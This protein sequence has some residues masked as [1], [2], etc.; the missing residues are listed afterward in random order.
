MFDLNDLLLAVGF[1]IPVF[2]VW[3]FALAGGRE[4]L[5]YLR[6]LPAS[7][8]VGLLA[9]LGIAVL[10]GGDKPPPPV[11]AVIQQILTVEA[12]GTLKDLSGEV[13][14]GVAAAALDAYVGASAAIVQ[15]ASNVVESARGDLAALT[16]AMAQANYQAAYI[17]Y[18]APRGTPAVSN[19]NIMV[20]FERVKQTPTNL[21]CLVWFSEL[22]STSV[23]VYAQ[24]AIAEGVWRDLAPLTN[25]WPAT[26]T[27][28][29]VEC[30]RYRYSLPAE[31]AGTP[32]RP[33][34][35][36]QFGGYGAGQY[37]GVPVEGITVETNGVTFQPFTGWDT[38]PLD[39][40]TNV[41]IHSVG[42]LAVELVL[43]GVSYKGV[44]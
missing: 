5:R 11:P 8:R 19:H 29:A 28:G 7:G 14:S 16:N 31:I 33:Q 24:Y 6:R 32:L 27:V 23:V 40:G 44:N 21:D 9:L 30:V 20:S 38:W 12:D 18:D 34:Y 10:Y 3:R 13:A 39:G 22:P 15:A 43:D 36:V 35:E 2:F 25:F 42:G 17:A 4:L 41:E 37:L 26:E 1:F